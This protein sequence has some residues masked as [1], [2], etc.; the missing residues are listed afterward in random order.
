MACSV[1]GAFCQRRATRPV[2]AP[3]RAS[4]LGQ[5][6][7]EGVLLAGVVAAE[8]HHAPIVGRQGHL[9]A[10]AELGPRP[11]HRV[12]RRGQ[13]PERPVPAVAPQRDD[14][15]QVRRQHRDLARAATGAQV[16]RSSVVGLLAGGAQ[17]T[18]AT[19]RA[20]TSRCP[21]PA[22][23]LVAWVARPTRCRLANSQSPERS[24]VKTRPVR[25]PPLAAG[26]SPTMSTARLRRR[27]SRRS[28]GPSRAG[29]R[30]T[31]AWSCATSSRQATSRGQAEQT[32]TR[33]S[34][35]AERARCR[36]GGV[37]RR[38]RAR[39]GCPAPPGPRASRC[40]AARARR[41]AAPV[42]GC[43]SGR[44][45]HRPRDAVEDVGLRDHAAWRGARRSTR[46]RISAPAP[47]TSARPGCM[48]GSSSAR[49]TGIATSR[50]TTRARRST[51][52]TAWSIAFRSYAGRSST[53]AATVSAVPATPTT[54]AA[55]GGRRPGRRR[56]A[57]SISATQAAT[58]VGVGG[59]ACR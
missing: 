56:G 55:V 24:P 6:A 20:P 7:G 42:N 22:C 1:T 33:A 31:P 38:G 5:P 15:P 27:P 28:A 19:I 51:A 29:R 57:A 3:R 8:Q 49:A 45:H 47:M 30:T 13:G 44:S 10:V 46:R 21:S 37:R 59:S 40:P 14:H 11:R 54:V 16:S 23:S 41:R 34:S 52:T 43:G 25:L 58:C 18:A 36:R 48:H 12:A 53:P 4:G 17:R 2:R 32:L 50:S 35:S 39:P 9:G 26:A